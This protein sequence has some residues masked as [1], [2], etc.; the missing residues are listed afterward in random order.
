MLRAVQEQGKDRQDRECVIAH[1][2]LLI[3][4]LSDEEFIV[5]TLTD[6]GEYMTA[7]SP[8]EGGVLFDVST[9]W[10]GQEYD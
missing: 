1:G 2:V 8:G 5:R 6:V 4:N 3:F 9:W 10:Y 7:L